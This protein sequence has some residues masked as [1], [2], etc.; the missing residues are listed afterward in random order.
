MVYTGGGHYQTVAMLPGSYEVWV[1]KTGFESDV[2]KIQV[3]AGGELKV[4]FSLTEVAPQAV[5]QG[6]FMGLDRGGRAKE[7]LLLSYDELYPDDPIKPVF[8]Q[9]CIQCHGKSFITF[10][11]KSTEEWDKTIGAML[12]TRIPPGTVDASQRQGTGSVPELSL[13]FRQPRPPDEVGCGGTRWM[14]KP[15]PKPSMW[16]ISLPLDEARPRRWVQE[17]HIDFEGNVWYTERTLPHA[18][19]PTRSAYGRGHRFRV[20]GPGGRSPRPDR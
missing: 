18:V 15:S 1:E 4:D 6:T 10:F 5:G 2:E 19:G 9:N 17:V 12:E 14:R 11:H 16:S 3:E 7:A 20:A 8:E 13:R